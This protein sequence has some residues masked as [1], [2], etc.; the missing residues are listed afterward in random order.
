MAVDAQTIETYDNTVIREDLEQQY[1]MISPE[2][3]PF[4]TAIGVGPAA[5]NTYHEW[6]VVELASPSTSNR[7]IE[8]DDAPGEDNGTLGKRFGNYTQISDKI[9]SVSNTSEAVDAAA[10]NVQRLAAQVAIK[11]K[12]MKR[13]ME[14]MLLQN[15]AAAAGSSG[16]ARQAAG[17]PAWLRTNIVLGASG[18]AP[19]L[20]GT[21]TGY[22][23]AALTPG[24]AVVLTET[25]LNN[26]IQSCW[27]EGASPSI[28][29][30]NANN[31]RVISKNFTGNATRYKDAIDK[32]L[33]AAIDIYDSDFGELSVVPNRFQQTTAA[34][35][36]S[37]Y[38]LDPEYA[39]LSFLETPRQTEL[40]QTGHAKRRMVHCEYT[41]KVS[42]EKAHG[43]IHATTGAAA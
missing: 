16:T 3:T 8:G 2:E 25:N 29:M 38:V 9:V 23:N 28:I 5:T 18:A 36:Y 42:N 39:S 12:E 31:K 35:N 10:E 40:A 37:V 30:V 17:L 6:T 13:D 15:I 34:D 11:L 19:T 43:A 27:N 32:R 41:L 1:T 24:T 21:T 7:V 14:A 26:V 22:P 33:T 4:Q 20:S